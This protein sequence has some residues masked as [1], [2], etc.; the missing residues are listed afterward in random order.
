[1][2][3]TINWIFGIISTGAIGF[4]SWSLK[5]LYNQHRAEKAETRQLI[6]EQGKKN[7]EQ[8]EKLENKIYRLEEKLP[9]KYVLKEDFYREINKLDMKL[10]SIKADV[11]ELNKNVASLLTIAKGEYKG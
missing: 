5:E 11:S 7:K 10:D 6:A 9:E 1:M 3:I 4:I 8:N 2:E